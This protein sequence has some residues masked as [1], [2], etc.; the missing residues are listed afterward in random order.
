MQIDA[1]GCFNHCAVCRR[2]GAYRQRGVH[3]HCLF[4]YMWVICAL[5]QKNKITVR[6]RHYFVAFGSYQGTTIQKKSAESS[7]MTTTT[8]TGVN[9]NTFAIIRLRSGLHA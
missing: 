1:L 2:G 3:R 6:F 7:M 9:V 8:T 4:F 5:G